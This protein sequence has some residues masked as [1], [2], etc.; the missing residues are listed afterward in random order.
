MTKAGRVPGF[1]KVARE[2]VLEMP[3]RYDGYREQLV[4]KLA[5]VI[6]CQSSGFSTTARRREVRRVLKAL[7][8]QVAAETR[9]VEEE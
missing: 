9:R 7:G 6:G 1:T 4:R 8:Q 2:V 5:E 3:E